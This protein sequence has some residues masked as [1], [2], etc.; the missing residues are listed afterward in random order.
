MRAPQRLSHTSTLDLKGCF[1]PR[2]VIPL[3][4]RYVRIC[5]PAFL[6]WPNCGRG[7]LSWY[8]DG[9]CG[10][11]LLQIYHRHV[12]GLIILSFGLYL[13]FTV[14][15]R[16][17][18]DLTEYPD[19]IREMTLVHCPGIGIFCG[20]SLTSFNQSLILYTTCLTHSLTRHQSRDPRR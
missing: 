14:D 7:F 9:S 15:Q 18:T 16:K 4:R 13:A 10:A 12:L 11:H 5:V 1:H 8:Q 6:C 3:V 20:S 17:I 2:T 19:R